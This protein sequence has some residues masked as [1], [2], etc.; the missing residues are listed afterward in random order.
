MLR[1]FF[2]VFLFLC[3]GLFPTAC[4]DETY[5]NNDLMD[6]GTR[7][8]YDTRLVSLCLITDNFTEDEYNRLKT[9]LKNVE[10]SF[11]E[12]DLR[13]YIS[14]HENET[15]LETND[16]FFVETRRKQFEADY[17]VSCNIVV[18]T[19]S[20]RIQT[21]GRKQAAG[22]TNTVSNGILIG[23]A[24]NA[25]PELLTLVIRHEIAHI[26]GAIHV[27]GENNVMTDTLRSKNQTEWDDKN[28]WIIE[29]YRDKFK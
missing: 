19:L 15:D 7:E 23:N 13:F 3:I 9:V 26:F 8:E 25:D 17:P 5:S 21:N 20:E 28:K 14:A 16:F 4:S 22:V 6:E 2:A 12:F 18:F 29:R 10:Q 1:I 27:E 11:E 24:D